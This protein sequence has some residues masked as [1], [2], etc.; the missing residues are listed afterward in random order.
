[1]P[2]IPQPY[3][4]TSSKRGKGSYGIDAPPAVRTLLIV[5][6]V[7]L[8]VALT[9][10]FQV[11]PVGNQLGTILASAG[12][13]TAI[14]C[15]AGAAYTLFSS[16]LGKRME[17]TRVMGLIPWGGG[18]RVLDV[19]CGR[20]LFLVAAAKRLGTGRAFGIDIWKAE[21]QSGNKPAATKMNTSIE[22]VA[23][24]ADVMSADARQLPFRDGSF[25]VILSNL[26]LHNIHGKEKRLRALKEIARVLRPGGSV[27]ISD[28]LHTGEYARVLTD[29]GL[30]EV[31]RSWIHP[32][33]FF[34]RQVTARKP[35]AWT[36]GPQIR[37]PR[38]NNR[39]E[40]AR[41]E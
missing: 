41:M 18:E 4:T 31:R 33:S 8:V 11:L 28:M 13:N 32:N 20:G 5:A 12:M 39:A 10:V 35:P 15:Y 3:I 34:V 19:G 37:E 9:A 38:D 27:V 6:S 7:G 1:M 23:D 17:L 2:E 25:D 29:C 40:A 16:T 30:A 21:D 14:G 22:G 26:C 24:R 36:G